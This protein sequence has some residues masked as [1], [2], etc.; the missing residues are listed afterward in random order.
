VTRGYG[1]AEFREELKGF[2][3][4][5]GV[6]NKAVMFLVTDTQIVDECFMEDINNMLGSGQVPNLFAPEE[7]ERV[8]ADMRP[9]L[10]KQGQPDTVDN[11]MRAFIERVRDNLHI[12]LCVSP[13]GDSL[14]VRC[15]KFPGLINCCTI[16]WYL[17][18]PE[19]ALESVA[20]RLLAPV[21]LPSDEIRAC[22]VQACVQV[23]TSINIAAEH[24]V[25]ELSRPTYTTP[26]SYLNAIQLYIGMLTSTCT[27]M[28][29]SRNRLSNGVVKLEETTTVVEQLKLELGR[30]MPTLKIK[31][32]ETELL[33]KEV[34]MERQEASVVQER[35]AKEKTE[36]NTQ[37]AEVS[38][39]QADAQK[40]LDKALP[41]LNSAIRA[42]DGLEKKDITE[43]KSFAKPP[44]AVRTVMEAVN[45]LLGEAT[46][47]D[48]CK[49]DA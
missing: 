37:A 25:N 10:V 43:L 20:E 36:V 9:I 22:L 21:E 4:Q 19:A 1:I 23:H 45:L 39:L 42:L 29:E 13:V 48:S 5:A 16:D 47:W 14:R 18:W 34:A 30:L 7:T 12:V 17:P 49:C 3:L 8:I 40:E 24:F 46:D 27:R 31:S 32:E 11:C 15:R 41:A 38:V 28:E 35:V 33:L 2:V 44:P 6:D 26:K